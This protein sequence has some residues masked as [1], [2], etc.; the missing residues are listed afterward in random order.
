MSLEGNVI[1][2]TGKL[3]LGTRATV[4]ALVEAHGGAFAT[5]VKK[6]VTH[7][8]TSEP[9]AGTS[10]LVAA[11][12]LGVRVVGEDFLSHLTENEPPAKRPKHQASLLVPYGPTCLTAFVFHIDGALS[13]LA[14]DDCVRFIRDHGGVYAEIADSSVTHVICQSTTPRTNANLGQ[15]TVVTED[16]IQA[17]IAAQYETLFGADEAPS[18]PSPKRIMVDGE[19]IE[20]EG[21]HGMYE[22]R[23][24]NGIYYCTC[25]AWKMQ[26]QAGAIR[27]CKHLREVLGDA[28]EAWRTKSN[29]PPAGLTTRVA[30]QSAPKL[31]LAHK[32]EPGTDI[33]GWHMSEKFDG[34]RGYW[35]GS[36]F[37]SRLGNPF[38]APLYF[39]KDLPKDVHLDGELFLGR[40]QFEATISIVKNSHPENSKNW[41][42]LKF[43]V[44]D[45]PTMKEK[46][47]EER[48][49]YLKQRFA[50]C[51]YVTVVDHKLC[52]SEAAL[53]AELARVE[54]LGAEGVMLRQPGSMYVGSRSTTL[55]KVKSFSD[56][57]AKIVGYEAGTGK[58][59]GR[60]G[61]LKC[62]SR[63]GKSFKVGSGLSDK[64]RDNPPAIGTLITYRYQELT[65]AGIPRFPTYVGIAIDKVWTDA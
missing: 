20:V 35:N 56:D 19:A 48:L 36:T 12:K 61:S 9:D 10:K 32:Y 47:F 2:I 39:T 26:H 50:K 29:M 62:I 3:S 34:V 63:S 46:P 5:A 8:V 38:T 25:M 51:E 41:A 33:S 17:L 6:G 55:L 14:K 52:A 22:V 30:K 23:L 43:M 54:A 1:A 45:V 4:Q 40:K 42:Q 57:E 27:T 13:T 53:N 18:G 28:F 37:L 15:P 64:L 7:L 65:A 49:A 16:A 60:T 44:F 58:H 11:R 59:K 24:R 31:L 21:G